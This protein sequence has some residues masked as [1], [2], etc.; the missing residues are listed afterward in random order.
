MITKLNPKK[1]ELLD[2]RWKLFESAT[3]DPELRFPDPNDYYIIA[4]DCASGLPGRNGTAATVLSF[5]RHEQVS[6]LAGQISPEETAVQIELAGWFFNCAELVI[7]R[8]THGAVVINTLYQRYPRLYRHIQSATGW[9]QK[10]T[11]DYGWNPGKTGYSGVSNRQIAVDLLVRD[12]GYIVSESE[13]ERKKA[14]RIND[15]ETIEEM[16]RFVPSR[17]KK[18]GA[19]GKPQAAPG[20]F[21]DRVSALY[22][23][24]F[25]W[26]ER[27]NSVFEKQKE[28]ETTVWDRMRLYSRQNPTAGFDDDES[29]TLGPEVG[30]LY[31]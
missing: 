19:A 14:I 29:R 16:Q 11:L 5:Q 20:K 9:Q 30:G 21:D 17:E 7:E 18:S 27:Q 10:S 22:I 25:V 23:A 1:Q 15:R 4:A 12:V 8:Q 31:D 26:N 13:L 6:I 3:N 2:G 24:N 28:V